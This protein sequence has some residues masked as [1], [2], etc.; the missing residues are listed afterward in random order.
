MA[1]APSLKRRATTVVDSSRPAKRSRPTVVLKGQRRR[2]GRRRNQDQLKT[3]EPEF[4]CELLQFYQSNPTI[5]TCSRIL[6]NA[7][8]RNRWQVEWGPEEDG[9]DLRPLTP[10]FFNTA[11][12]KNALKTFLVEAR[13]W[14]R[15]FRF[16][17]L[18]YVKDPV[19]WLQEYTQKPYEARELEPLPF[20][21]A[22]TTMGVVR[23]RVA[24][25]R[26]H[27]TVEFEPRD[28]PTIR[29]R[30]AFTVITQN[31]KFV[32]LYSCVP[33]SSFS[34]LLLNARVLEEAKSNLHD[35]DWK[36]THPTPLLVTAMMPD[37][38][39][40]DVEESM[41]YAHNSVQDAKM[42]MS[43][44]RYKVSFREA[45]A[46]IQ[47]IQS[48]L[49]GFKKTRGLDGETLRS[50]K[51]ETFER[52]D[53]D[54]GFITLP[55]F[56]KPVMPAPAASL[57]DR[58]KLRTEFAQG[59]CQLMGVP[60]PVFQTE[61]IAQRQR[62]SASFD[63]IDQRLHEDIINEQL[64]MA[65]VFETVYMTVYGDLDATI[66]RHLMGDE[67]TPKEL[68]AMITSMTAAGISHARLRFE[69]IMVRSASALPQLQALHKE[70]LVSENFMRHVVADLFGK[71][72]EDQ[73]DP[74]ATSLRADRDDR[75][76][77][78]E[79]AAMG[80]DGS[81]GADADG[82]VKTK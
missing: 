80:V 11:Q 66:F 31:P 41:L 29:R 48:Q 35:A 67:T 76:E 49:S 27:P 9:D 74:E 13:Q 73:C 23:V 15:L 82:D 57:I 47:H 6:N 53:L 46:V 24:E 2:R 68:R 58:E 75:A 20:G 14:M 45:A 37:V 8:F 38:Q 78:P 36:R 69:T 56:V 51:K 72:L 17:V 7:V 42:H 33:F 21:V 52:S 60:F 61:F 30:Y 12:T 43:A 62:V 65:R 39:T 79:T 19:R 40:Q 50:M 32:D 4:L 25:S 1:A 16:F 81:G 26:L 59:V 28:N 55:D 71:L 3:I 34:E 5:Q 18:W 44:R 77:K 70:G 54:E 63:M 10:F 22:D 64:K